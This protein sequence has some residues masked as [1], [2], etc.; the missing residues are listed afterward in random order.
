MKR[1]ALLIGRSSN[2]RG[3]SIRLQWDVRGL[4]LPRTGLHRPI[5]MPALWRQLFFLRFDDNYFSLS[6]TTTLDS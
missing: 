5:V 3:G 6:T 1:L 4:K 2:E